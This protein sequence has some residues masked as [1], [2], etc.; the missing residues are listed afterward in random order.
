MKNDQFN[1]N[2]LREALQYRGKRMADLV[3]E[4]GISRQSFSAYAN[5]TNRPSQENV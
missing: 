2:R 3:E 5:G 1:G 4:T